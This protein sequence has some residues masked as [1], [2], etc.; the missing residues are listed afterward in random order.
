MAGPLRL[1][2]ATWYGA[3]NLTPILA[4][5]NALVRRGHLVYALAHD[6]Q[7]ASIQAAGGSFLGFGS[8]AQIDHGRSQPLG[9]SPIDSLIELDG[10][11]SRD[12]LAACEWLAPDAL[13]VDCM[14]PN[15]LRAAKRTGQPT[16]ALVHALYGA[17]V[18]CAG[19]VFRSPIDEADLALG[20]TYAALDAAAA[21]PANFVFVGPARLPATATSWTRRRPG[22]PLVIVSLSTGLQGKPGTQHALLQR[23]CDALAPLDIE[24]LVT[25]GRGI[26][27]ESVAAG[28]STMVARFAPHELVL[29][30]ADLFQPVAGFRDAERSE[31]RFGARGM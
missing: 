22:L 26:A 8:G 19:G 10:D 5:V 13:L 18:V 15:T 4:L 1:L 14:L 30:Q 27:P 31:A 29:P 16:I 24:A 12:L 17:F 20:F 2:V 25:T 11:V 7:R 28:P 9:D 23:L 21:V 6:V 3:G